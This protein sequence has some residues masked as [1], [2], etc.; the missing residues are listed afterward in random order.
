MGKK[1]LVAGNNA[2]ESVVEKLVSEGYQLIARSSARFRDKSSFFQPFYDQDDIAFQNAELI[3]G[4]D[5]VFVQSTAASSDI[6]QDSYAMMAL[7]MAD[8]LKKYGAATVTAVLPFAPYERQ[9][10]RKSDKTFPSMMG[11]LYPRLLKEA[12][13]DKVLSYSS[14]SHKAVEHW[15]AAFGKCYS[16]TENSAVLAGEIL[17]HAMRNNLDLV[18]GAPDGSNKPND[19]AQEQAKK[20][21]AILSTA[22]KQ[23]VPMFFIE[24]IHT[25]VNETQVKGFQGDVAGKD[26]VVIDDMSDSGGTGM[27]AARA[28]WERGAKSVTFALGN[29]LVNKEALADMLSAKVPGNANK[30]LFTHLIFTDSCPDIS[31]TITSLERQFPDIRERIT[32]VSTATAIAKDLAELEK[33]QVP[34]AGRV[35]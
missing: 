19:M 32:V 24:K 10:G 2:P 35:K 29:A 22:L 17:A 20:T 1:L 5:V 23:D 33:V 8:T 7:A 16:Y 3:N 6:S 28:L 34:S 25:G 30:K 12:G 13:A 31:N 4:A 15:R 27:N 18:V 14:H 11:N 9:D 26:C 21:K